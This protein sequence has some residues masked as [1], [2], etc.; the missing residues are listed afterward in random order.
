MAEVALSKGH[1]STEKAT[2]DVAT[3]LAGEV[4]FADIVPE[5]KNR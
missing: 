1:R 5:E 3:D 2:K 4:L